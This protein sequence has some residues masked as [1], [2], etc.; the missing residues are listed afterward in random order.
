M[1]ESRETSATGN[2]SAGAATRAAWTTWAIGL[3]AAVSFVLFAVVFLKIYE[4]D[5]PVRDS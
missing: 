1:T 4:Q 2:P 5:G 3:V